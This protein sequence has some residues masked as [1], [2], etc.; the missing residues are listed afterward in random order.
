MV[1]HC[2]ANH[3][4]VIKDHLQINRN[5]KHACKRFAPTVRLM[6]P[7]REYF[8]WIAAIDNQSQVEIT[9]LSKASLGARAECVNCEH[10][11]LARCPTDD[12]ILPA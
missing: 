1:A 11:T 9:I 7:I 4:V 6:D 10:Q 3:L 12:G 2:R 8:L 5:W